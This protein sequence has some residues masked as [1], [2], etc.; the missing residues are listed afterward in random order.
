MQKLRVESFSISIDGFGA[1]TNQSLE[2]PLGNRGTNLHKWFF[3]TE[4]FQK[5]VM[6]KNEGTTGIDNEFAKRGFNNIGA[7]IL[8]RNMFSPTRGPWLDENWK[9]WWGDNPPYQVPVFI[10]TN[11]PRK[12]I[13]MNGGTTF[14]FITDGIHSALK[15]AFDSANGKDVRIGGGVNVIRQYLKEKLIDELHIAVSPVFLGAGENLFAGMNL[16]DL[17]YNITENVS[18]EYA[19]HLIIK[20]KTKIN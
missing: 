10:L 7:W 12:S 3:P 8:G 2:N 1:G 19:T 15:K 16:L 4:I 18:T 17:G 14:H 11:Y 5:N 13:E 6:G 20:N 9:G